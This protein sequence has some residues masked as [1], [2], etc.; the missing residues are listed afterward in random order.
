[1]P[2]IKT[3]H[4]PS[5]KRT[6]QTAKFPKQFQQSTSPQQLEP[7]I[8]IP[9]NECKFRVNSHSRNY[10]ANGRRQGA[11]RL[12]KRTLA[13][14]ALALCYCTRCAIHTN[15]GREIRQIRDIL[16]LGHVA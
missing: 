7:T 2:E 1:M 15:Y 3:V 16:V 14:C 13:H 11:K 9:N 5:T 6:L 12:S 4:N 10:S 8:T